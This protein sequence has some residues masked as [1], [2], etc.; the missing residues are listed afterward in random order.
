MRVTQETDSMAQEFGNTHNSTQGDPVTCREAEIIF[1][2]NVVSRDFL[3]EFQAKRM[4]EGWSSKGTKQEAPNTFPHT[5]QGKG[6]Q[7]PDC[8]RSH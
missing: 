3:E 2:S 8:P 5:G 6:G 7:A 1:Y 4:V